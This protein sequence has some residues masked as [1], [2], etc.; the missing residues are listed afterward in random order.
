MSEIIINKN[1][2][3]N[4]NTVFCNGVSLLNSDPNSFT[5][6]AEYSYFAYDKNQVYALSSSAEGIQIWDDIDIETL[7]FIKN[8]DYFTDKNHLYYF[9]FYFIEYKNHFM[10]DLVENLMVEFFYK[11]ENGEHIPTGISENEKSEIIKREGTIK[12]FLQHYHPKND[13]WWNNDE[14]FYEKLIFLE[15]HIY[16]FQNKVYFLVDTTFGYPFYNVERNS[17]YFTIIPNADFDSFKSLDKYYSKDKNQVFHVAR[18][19][20]NIN[21]VSFVSLGSNFAKTNSQIFYNGYICIDADVNSFEIIN[22]NFAKDKT[23]LFAVVPSARISKYK[24]YASLLQKLEKTD[25][26]S[27]KIINSRWSKTENY[28]V[29]YN[30]IWKKIDAKSFE[31]LFN[32]NNHSWAKCNN[33]FYNA[34][35]RRTVKGVDGKT[36][37]VLNTFWGKDKNVVFNFISGRIMTSI[38]AQTFEITNEIGGAKDQNFTYY[39]DENNDVKKEK[40]W[41]IHIQEKN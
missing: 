33:G 12:L 5:I 28:V 6:V 2:S 21:P 36:F 31:F 37:K 17:N 13:A 7:I 3:K 19:L 23:N 20:K 8:T 40:L 39:F 16:H 30:K 11:F 27:F 38:N 18:K 22:E 25:P 35:G 41:K 34:N 14:A 32:D 4:K 15:N 1:Y 29:C 10:D 24:G 9:N 26:K